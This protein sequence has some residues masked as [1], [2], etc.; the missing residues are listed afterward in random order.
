MPQFQSTQ[1]FPRPL[2]E[3]FA[4]FQRLANLELITPPELNL[5]VEEGPDLLQ[6]GSRL[7]LRARRW[8]VP[9][10]ILSE[11]VAF[12]PNVSFTDRQI[13]GPFRQWS[14]THRFEEVP[15]GTR[16]TD[17]IEYEPPGGL[18]GLVVSAGMIDR[19]LTW[20]FDYRRR[21]LAELLGSPPGAA[22]A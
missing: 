8:G 11:I 17:V 16:V 6:L 15:E 10:V 5:R 7:R 9:Q 18:L 14:H 3:V 22:G 13:E 21:K 4:F 1:T 12:E 19:D 2:A 20:I